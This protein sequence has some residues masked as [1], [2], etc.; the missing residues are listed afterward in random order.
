MSS[1]SQAARPQCG[2]CM[3]STFYI[4]YSMKKALN[5]LQEEPHK[6]FQKFR[7]IV[8]T[9]YSTFQFLLSVPLAASSSP[10]RHTD[11]LARSTCQSPLTFCLFLSFTATG[12]IEQNR[13]CVP[14]PNRPEHR[15]HLSLRGVRRFAILS[16]RTARGRDACVS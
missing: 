1:P 7:Q 6:T 10:K 16:D 12:A 5:G 11:L 3:H 4:A 2:H 13:Q 8:Y 14:Q 15:G 9:N